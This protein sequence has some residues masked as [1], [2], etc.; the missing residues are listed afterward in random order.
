MAGQRDAGSTATTSMKHRRTWFGVLLWLLVCTGNHLAHSLW[1]RAGRSE[2]AEHA[3]LR[4]VVRDEVAEDGRKV[5]GIDEQK[6]G[7]PADRLILFSQL[8]SWAYDSGQDQ[9]PPHIRSLNDKPRTLV[10]F[11]S[12]LEPGSQVKSF[13]LSRHTAPGSRPKRN[14]VVAVR[15]PAPVPF[16]EQTPV[17]VQ[18][19]FWVSPN[20]STLPLYSVEANRVVQVRVPVPDLPRAPASGRTIDFDFAW[21]KPLATLKPGEAL[22]AGLLSHDGRAVTV[23]GQVMASEPCYPPVFLVGHHHQESCESHC[24][25]N[26]R[27]HNSIPVRMKQEAPVP[28]FLKPM[29]AFTGTLKIN[30]DPATW[31]KQ[32]IAMIEEAVYRDVHRPVDAPPPLLPVW[33]EVAWAAGLMLWIAK[34][35]ML[36]RHYG[37]RLQTGDM[38]TQVAAFIALTDS[39]REGERA[40]SITAALGEPHGRYAQTPEDATPSGGADEVWVYAFERALDGPFLKPVQPGEPPSDWDGWEIGQYGMLLD[41]SR[42]RIVSWRV[43]AQAGA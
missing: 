11:M 29:A 17:A 7:E 35:T 34:P 16:E 28:I 33:L 25:Q 31:L 27:I 23:T 37:K 42:S 18:G 1:P 30:R 2:Q 12:P 40:K 21:L 8:E 10:G 38:Y 32:P 15:A 22:P 41:V 4:V 43:W 36:R 6:L 14:R 26:P 19:R 9:P 13:M 5:L 39:L 24:E 3:D 20:A